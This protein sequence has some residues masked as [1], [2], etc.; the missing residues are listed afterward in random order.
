MNLP[1]VRNAGPNN[2]VFRY[3][4]TVRCFSGRF[5]CASQESDG[6]FSQ[7]EF[8]FYLLSLF[9]KTIFI[10]LALTLL[11]TCKS[12][13]ETTANRFHF[14]WL[15]GSWV[16]PTD[17]GMITEDWTIMNDNLLTG[18]SAIVKNGSVQPFE[19]IMLTVT[20]NKA[21]YIVSAA[22]SSAGNRTVAFAITQH[23][24]KSFTAES[25]ANDFPKR[26]TYQLIRRDSIHAWIDGGE[27]EPTKR[28][29]FYYK[30]KS[31]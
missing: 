5:F 4:Q 12:S 26:I 17:D 19:T 22:D 9:M 1:S 10:L 25:L 14:E 23:N 24:K 30:R 20:N 2:L 6:R 7:P 15:A 27:Q 13:K 21:S 31:K 8:V 11:A 3:T 18:S 16:M 29:D 28:V